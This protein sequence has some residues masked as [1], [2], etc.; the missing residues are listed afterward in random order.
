MRTAVEQEIGGTSVTGLPTTASSLVVCSLEEWGTVR[1]RIRI[2]VDELVDRD[3]DLRV[4]YVAPAVDV[5]F[6]LRHGRVA[7]LTRPR[8]EQVHPRVHVLRPRKWIPRAVGPFADRALGQQVARAVDE[9]GLVDPLVWVNDASYA[10]YALST[11]WPTL[12]DITDDWLLAPLSPRREARL[13]AD[14]DL[15]LAGSGAVVVCSPDLARSRGGRRS[16][17]LI[18]NGVDVDLFRAQTPRRGGCVDRGVPRSNHHNAPSNGNG[19]SLIIR[20]EFNCV[21]NAV[22]FLTGNFH[23][24]R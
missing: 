21:H 2:L 14:D 4:L 9:L 16:V 11:G 24:V 18:P 15:L 19:R 1:R 7:G 5:P 3:P 22:Q 17:D 12:Y 10:R 6:E 13:R 20:D 8:L 23:P